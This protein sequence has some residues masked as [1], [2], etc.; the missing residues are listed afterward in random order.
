MPALA[1]LVVLVVA[2]LVITSLAGGYD[3]VAV[4][5]AFW[6]G[7]FG[8]SDALL[9]STLVR[10]TPLIL[11]GLAVAFAFRAG[12]LNIG[13]EGQILAGAAAA[14]TVALTLADRPAALV[15]TAALVAGAAG[16]AAWALLPA[17]L[18][19]WFG[20]L[21]VISTI[22]MNFVALHGVGYLV[23][24][25]LQEVLGIYPQSSTL[26]D[27][28][29]LPMMVPGTRLHLGFALAL[30]VSIALAVILRSTAAGF[31]IR[32]TGENPFAA[33]IAGGIDV[34]RTGMRVFLMSGAIA[35]L[36]GAIEVLGV[37]FA[38]YENLSP[39]FGYTAIA[40][41]LLG[42]LDP[43]RVMLSGIFFGALEAGAGAMQRDAG[44]PSVLVSVIQ[45]MIILGLL[46]TAWWRAK[47]AAAPPPVPGAS[48]GE[49]LDEATAG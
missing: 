45:A 31:R 10:A 30:V 28:V 48:E 32:V 27:A 19:R 49:R 42:A 17:I 34:Q 40:V 25:P 26:P 37:T 38:L 21:D 41:A 44:V 14:T 13:A 39:G 46:A 22:M 29:H 7:S 20:V 8:S 1:L 43:V 6:R 12:I 3:A 2:I 16:G 5:R 15:I 24:G 35:G 47:R 9:S 33:R 36:A 23:R 11:A 4:M 18:L